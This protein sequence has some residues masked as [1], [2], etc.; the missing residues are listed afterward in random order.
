MEEVEGKDRF[1]ND[2]TDSYLENGLI[3]RC[4]QTDISHEFEF[5]GDTYSSD[6]LSR[7]ETVK[8]YQRTYHSFVRLLRDQYDRLL[9][10]FY[11]RYANF[12]GRADREDYLWVVMQDQLDADL[13]SYMPR[14]GR[15]RKPYIAGDEERWMAAH[16]YVG[17]QHP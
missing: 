15:L 10:F 2:Y 14:F 1:G 17:K 6:I 12:D 13:F 16:Q 3:Y 5:L 4:T 9:L 7:A 11:D 8:E